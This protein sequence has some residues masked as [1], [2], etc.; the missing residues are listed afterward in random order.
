MDLSSTL[1]RAC[2][3]L[4][5]RLGVD[6]VRYRPLAKRLARHS[7]DTVL[8]VGAN[9]GQFRRALRACGFEGRIVSFEP[10]RACFEK[11]IGSGR[12]DL[13]FSAQPYALGSCNG[14]ARIVV[15]KN[16]VFSSFRR[17][18]D[19]LLHVDGG[20]E[21]RGEENV[22]VRRLEDL[23]TPL[24]LDGSRVFLKI[25]TQGSD[26]D[27]LLG[28]GSRLRFL[29]GL[30]TELSFHPFYADQPNVAAVHR[31]LVDEGFLLESLTEAFRDFER[32]VL[33]EMDA[34]YWKSDRPLRG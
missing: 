30:Q 16:P 15:A 1:L 33:M 31:F 5:R 25:D 28:C 24:G 13:L 32:G 29:V 3:S 18:K 26:Y 20:A 19:D 34:V 21:A 23:W 9:T 14:H 22:E 17:V 10:V 11:L 2:H 6:V 4:I 8:D 12:G 7:V 27:V